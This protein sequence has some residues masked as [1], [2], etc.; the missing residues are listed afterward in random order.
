MQKPVSTHSFRMHRRLFRFLCIFQT[1]NKVIRSESIG[2][3]AMLLR[4][5]IGNKVFSDPKFSEGIVIIFAMK[6]YF[7]STTLVT[8]REPHK[9]KTLLPH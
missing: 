2:G 3:S 1:Q 5:K 9:I 6:P 8:I 7:F 4:L